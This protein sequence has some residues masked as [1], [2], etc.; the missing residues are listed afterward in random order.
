M[1]FTWLQLGV[2]PTY[3]KQTLQKLYEPPHAAMHNA[4]QP[5]KLSSLAIQG[6]YGIYWDD[7]R[8]VY[9]HYSMGLYV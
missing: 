8:F 9:G 7:I 5:K 3:I 6:F 1:D 2:L 4:H